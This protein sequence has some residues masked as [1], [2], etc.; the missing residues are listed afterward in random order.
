MTEINRYN[1]TQC[2]KLMNKRITV[3]ECDKCDKPCYKLTKF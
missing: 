2:V 3:S 1:T